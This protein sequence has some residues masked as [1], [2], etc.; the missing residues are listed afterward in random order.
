LGPRAIAT[1]PERTI[2]WIPEGAQ[3]LD[4]RLQLALVAGRLQHEALGVTS[5]T[6]RAEDCRRAQDLRAVL[7]LRVHPDQHQLALDVAARR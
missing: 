1:L 6:L 4:E 7:G 3:E 2:S 5:T